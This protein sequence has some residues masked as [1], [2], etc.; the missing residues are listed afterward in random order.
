MGTS[1]TIIWAEEWATKIQQELDE[2]LIWKE[3]CNVE[4]TNMRVLHNPYITDV[5]VQSGTRGS[6]YSLQ[7]IVLTD[8]YITISTY[9]VTAAFIDRAD[10]AQS[11]FA[12]QMTI[13]QR[14]G[15]ILNEAIQSAV[16]GAYG[17]MTDFG[18]ENL[19]GSSG[20]SAITVSE[21]N[22]DNI[23]RSIKRTIRT[24]NGEALMNRNGVFI[25]W[26]PADFELLE[27][28]MQAN[29]FVTADSALRGGAKLGVEY[30]G[31]THYSSNLL[32][33]SHLVAGVKKVLHVGIVKDTY[34]QIVVNDKD[35]AETSG[36]SIV[37]RVDYAVKVWTKVLPVLFDVNVA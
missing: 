17:S 11:T 16:L 14:Q 35:P 18:T 25:V 34:G 36:I 20:S 29:G 2:P 13:A 6:A 15:V 30:M 10:L 37:S 27:G 33:A 12:N 23:I 26:R 28:Y 5:T 31:V 19:S 9:K 4:Y 7:E 24:N 8:D 21:T 3:I 1:N 22:I 32:T